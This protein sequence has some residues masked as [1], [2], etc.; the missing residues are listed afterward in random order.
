MIAPATDVEQNHPIHDPFTL[1]LKQHRF[2]VTAIRTV[3]VVRSSQRGVLHQVVHD[4]WLLFC[5]GHEIVAVDERFARF[6]LV[7]A[8]ATCV[9]EDVVGAVYLRVE[10][11]VAFCA[12]VERGHGGLLELSREK[13]KR[14]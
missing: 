1:I 14:S 13:S 7:V 12:E 8:V 2:A 5:D 9:K 10:E 4:S 6:L 3:E 11:V